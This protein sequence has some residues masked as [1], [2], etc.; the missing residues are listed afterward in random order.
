MEKWQVRVARWWLKN[1]A[2]EYHLRRK[3]KK[4]PVVDRLNSEL[5][6]YQL[7]GFE[8]YE[9]RKENGTL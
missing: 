1:Y 3:H 7:Q 6:K 4:E 9:E 2:N 5:D 8:D